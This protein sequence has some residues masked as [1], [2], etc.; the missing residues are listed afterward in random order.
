MNSEFLAIGMPGTFELILIAGAALLI[1]GRRL[2]EVAMRGAAQVVGAS[3]SVDEE[4][5]ARLLL[6]VQQP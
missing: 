1:F 4:G 5:L 2:P 6:A 3:G